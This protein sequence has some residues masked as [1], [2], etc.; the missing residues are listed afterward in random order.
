MRITSVFYFLVLAA[1]FL[2]PG[3]SFGMGSPQMKPSFG[4]PNFNSIAWLYSDRDIR[5]ENPDIQFPDVKLTFANYLKQNNLS[6]NSDP[7]KVI[8]AVNSYCIEYSEEYKKRAS[9]LLQ[10]NEVGTYFS[11][12][13]NLFDTKI[14]KETVISEKLVNMIDQGL[15]DRHDMSYNF[16]VNGANLNSLRKI[17]KSIA[18]YSSTPFGMLRIRYEYS[19]AATQI[20]LIALLV[21]CIVA[22]FRKI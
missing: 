14:S 17:E 10:F 3:T 2:V 20:L 1:A 18:N 15:K 19:E 7:K 6:L 9:K 21:L 16:L 13:C 22:I 5:A 12:I 4:E 8:A 11:S